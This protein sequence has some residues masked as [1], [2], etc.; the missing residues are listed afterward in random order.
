MT[1]GSA[2]LLTLL[3]ADL[4]LFFLP[5]LSLLKIGAGK[6]ALDRWRLVASVGLVIGMPVAAVSLPQLDRIG[7]WPLIDL[8]IFSIGN[9]N[10]AV[11]SPKYSNMTSTWCYESLACPKVRT[12]SIRDCAS[13][14]SLLMALGPKSRAMTSSDK[15]GPV[16]A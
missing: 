15:N 16:K 7:C 5:A 1:I 4:C 12:N 2:L 9:G 6:F 3:F 13:T 10:V 8:V 11:G 14:H